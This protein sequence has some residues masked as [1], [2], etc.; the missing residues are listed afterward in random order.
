LRPEPG[1]APVEQAQRVVAIALGELQVVGLEVA[2]DDAA[3]VHRG[4]HVGDIHEQGRDLERG[5]AQHAVESCGESLTWY[6][7]HR[8]PRPVVG[9]HVAL[10]DAHHTRMPNVLEDRS[11]LHHTRRHPG[12]AAQ[13]RVHHLDGGATW[14]HD[15]RRLVDRTHP[16]APDLPHDPVRTDA[17][18]DAKVREYG[19]HAETLCRKLA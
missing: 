13:I 11:L 6:Q 16:S 9:K 7:L 12:M 10:V 4:E 19:C 17:C 1:D 15:V 2:M 18:I 14:K 3:Q 5:Q 8:D